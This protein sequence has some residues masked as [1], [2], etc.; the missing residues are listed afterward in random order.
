MR[1]D[2]A[3]DAFQ[4]K[5]DA[6][7]GHVRKARYRRDLFSDA[8]KGLEDVKE[9][10]PSGSLARGTQLDP[11]HDVD[12]IVIF[13]S[14][15]HPDWGK[16]GASAGAALRYALDEV[17][18]LLGSESSLLKKV[19]G[20]ISLRNHVVQCFLD[21]RFLAEDPDFKSF[22]A[23]EVMPSLRRK[24]TT[25]CIPEKKNKDW[26]VADPEWLIAEVRR[27]QDRWKYFVRM[28]R[29]IKYWMR[30]VNSNVKPLAA[31]VLALNCLP[32]VINGLRRPDALQRFFTAAAQA[33]MLPVTDPA[34]HCGEIQPGLK[35]LHV[36]GLLKEAADIAA[37]AIAWERQDEHHQAIC[38]W[39]AVFGEEFPL[40]PGGCPGWGPGRGGRGDA[41]DS[42]DPSPGDGEQVSSNQPPDGRGGLPP[43]D[44]R[45]PDHGDG[46]GPAG[47]GG[48]PAGGGPGGGPGGGGG[49]GSGSPGGNPGP[50]RG[51]IVPPPAPRK[52]PSPS[53]PVKEAPQ[54]CQRI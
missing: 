52:P 17:N 16:P 45:R 44:S 12:L 10:V 34:G 35:R 13:D 14:L 11:I 23:V 7:P 8:F 33:V 36:R 43:P 15:H 40:P 19:V 47:G 49:T 9:V 31:E 41:G 6:D 50:S 25:L 1:V 26:V 32:D 2:E 37:T 30:H 24:D 18:L 20:D 27:R 54:G 39:R 28:I 42:S 51:P 22:F 3:F 29:V 46:P 21:P 48:G 5:V 38:C 53:R 4:D